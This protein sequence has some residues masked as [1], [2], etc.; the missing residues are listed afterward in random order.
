MDPEDIDI[1]AADSLT[2][3]PPDPTPEPMTDDFNI[4]Q[5][6]FMSYSQLMGQMTLDPSVGTSCTE[7]HHTLSYDAL[8]PSTQVPETQALASQG[9]SILAVQSDQKTHTIHLSLGEYFVS[10]DLFF[11]FRIVV[12][13]L[14]YSKDY[15][16]FS[17]FII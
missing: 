3:G 11:Y 16:L 1:S 10:V 9:T 5:E 6:D 8:G 2:D 13:I 7:A 17:L 15:T 12:Y 4:F 14:F